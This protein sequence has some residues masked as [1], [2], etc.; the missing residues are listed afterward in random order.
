MLFPDIQIAWI[1]FAEPL[2]DEAFVRKRLE[3]FTTGA[4]LVL[5]TLSQEFPYYVL[6]GELP[7]PEN[8]IE[9][10]KI[11]KAHTRQE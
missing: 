5:K 4:A 2:I 3:A 7:T 11:Y 1:F 6:D 8:V 10:D 9:L